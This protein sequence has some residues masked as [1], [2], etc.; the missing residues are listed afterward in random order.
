[1][2]KT[3]LIIAIGLLAAC[4]GVK[5]TQEAVNSGNYTT[6]INKALKNLRENKTKKRNQS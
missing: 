4:G 3:V 2:K 5:K 6:A 1:M